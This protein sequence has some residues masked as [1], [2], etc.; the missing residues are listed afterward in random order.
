LAAITLIGIIPPTLLFQRE[1]PEDRGWL[2]D[3]EVLDEPLPQASILGRARVPFRPTRKD[4]T[5]R[6]ALATPTLWLLFAMRVATPLG[7]MMVTPHHVA[8]LVGRGFDKLTAAFAYGSLGAV[9]FTGR[10]V[11]SSVSDR[12]GRVPTLC[13]TY[14]I[15]ILGTI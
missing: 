3:G 4:W 13:F 12:I 7:M 8:Y 11:F 9:S 10:I 5:L 14:G 2:A 6:A 15:T 1:R